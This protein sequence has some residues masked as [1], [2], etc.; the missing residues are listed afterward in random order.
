MSTTRNAE[1][2]IVANL[3]SICFERRV[4]SGTILETVEVE[5]D[6]QPSRCGL[7]IVTFFQRVQYGMRRKITLQ[8][9]NQS[10]T[11]SDSWSRSA[12]TVINH[13]DRM[14]PGNDVMRMT[15]YRLWPSSPNPIIQSNH[16]RK[17]RRTPIEGHSTKH[18]TSTLQNCWCHQ[19][20]GKS[21]KLLQLRRAL[22]D[23]TR[24]L[25][26]FPGSD[27]GTEKEH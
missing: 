4:T 22:G 6:S 13:V 14:N 1:K 27:L 12:S 10:N 8:W 17:I 24:N 20:Q 19:K 21:S 26:W 18:L 15:L 5:R 9:R 2:H 16:K 7:H 3:Q 23:M 25:M 11:T